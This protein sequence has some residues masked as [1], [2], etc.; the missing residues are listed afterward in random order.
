MGEVA[1]LTQN[2]LLENN[3]TNDKSR[4]QA[5]EAD[6][7]NVWEGN[8]KDLVSGYKKLYATTYSSSVSF[9]AELMQ[10]FEQTEIVFGYDRVIKDF[11]DLLAAQEIL[12]KKIRNKE[13]QMFT[14]KK[15]NIAEAI[16]EG[17]ISLYVL[18][19]SISHQKFL[20]LEGYNG[21]TRVITGSAN[22]SS[23][24]FTGKQ[25]EGHVFFDNLQAFEYYLGIFESLKENSANCIDKEPIVL[26]AKKVEKAPEV[27]SPELTKSLPVIK[28]IVNAEYPQIGTLEEASEED[29]GREY[30]FIDV[31]KAKAKYKLNIPQN[32]NPKGKSTNV[33][34]MSPSMGKK[35]IENLDK[36]VMKELAFKKDLPELSVVLDEGGKV[37]LEETPLDLSPSFEDVKQDIELFIEYMAGFNMFKGEI[38]EQK[39]DFFAFS[40]WFFL[41]PFISLLRNAAF[42]TQ[43][44]IILY[45]AYG[46]LFGRTTAGKTSLLSTLLAIMFGAKYQTC[47][48]GNDMAMKKHMDIL[49]GTFGGFP[50]VIDDINNRK[51][52]NAVTEMIKNDYYNSSY[53]PCL[54]FSTNND[55]TYIKPEVSRRVVGCKVS[56]ALPREKMIGSSIV[57]K[58]ARKT[59]TAFYRE[60]LRRILP[61][62]I[63]C[64]NSLLGENDQEPDILHIS[65][66]V[67]T[68]IMKDHLDTKL[69]SW[70]QELHSGYYFQQMATKDSIKRIIK[71]WERGAEEFDV[72]RLRNELIVNIGDYSE[73]RNLVEELPPE[74]KAEQ[75]K[76]KIYMGLFEAENYFGIIFK[77]RHGF[78]RIFGRKQ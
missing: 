45:P 21:E 63:D 5:V 54:V 14:S 47:I 30:F 19:K 13:K 24:A 55:I 6:F 2:S 38:E 18:Q 75:Q 49:K 27:L 50:V 41:T 56:A 69:P 73:A 59:N 11:T 37:L 36:V 34:G 12:V 17:N 51:F 71:Y 64:Y 74:L 67:L 20:L 46:V 68:E 10:L 16:E 8:W 42:N 39:K 48:L 78:W 53:Y 9:V 3:D 60:Y 66:L 28:A 29:I 1:L 15:Q 4:I 52:N 26:E 72:N 62:I 25:G 40:N 77:R 44:S 31:E 76:E 58:V 61:H 65:S 43:K 23:A 33:S 35:I 22:L 32:D 70:V 7:K 57:K